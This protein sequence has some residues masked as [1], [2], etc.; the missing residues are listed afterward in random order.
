MSSILISGNV[1]VDVSPVTSNTLSLGLVWVSCDAFHREANS[2]DSSTFLPEALLYYDYA[3]TFGQEV[4]Y[5]WGKKLRLSNVAYIGCR[6][7]LVANVL[8]LLAMSGKLRF[9]VSA[10]FKVIHFC[11]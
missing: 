9:G 8:Y 6:Y 11:S 7:A 2:C 10:V 3:L 1:G 4:R 5:I